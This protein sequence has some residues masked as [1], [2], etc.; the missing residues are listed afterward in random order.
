[1]LLE[2]AENIFQ[3]LMGMAAL[4]LCLVRWIGQRRKEWLYAVGF[5]ICFLLATYYWTGYLVIW[6][7][8][9]DSTDFLDY[10][11]CNMALV[12]LLVL[13]FLLKSPA[14]RRYFHPL[15]L[16]PIP[17]NVWQLTLYLPYG[18][19]AN[20]IFQVTACT[21]IAC[22]ALR[23]LC[24]WYFKNRKAKTPIFAIAS[25]LFVCF[26]FGMWTSTCFDEPVANLYYPFSFLC[27]AD[28]LFLAWSLSRTLA[29]D[30]G[31]ESAQEEGNE[32]PKLW[33][34][35][36]FNLLAPMF[37]IFFLMILMVLY[38]SRV[39]RSV[40]TANVREMGEV[41]IASVTAQM[42]NYLEMT[43]SVMWVTADTVDHMFRNG[44]STQDILKY[45]TEESEKQEKH[46]DDNY[47]GIYG[48]V[49]GEYLDG[50]GW[51]PPED[52][53][54]TQRD[55]Y[56]AAIEAQGE[57]T[58][59]SPYVD[60]QT[61]AVII[62]ISRMLSNGQDV[63]S[64]DVRMNH[65]QEIVEDLQVKGKGYGFVVNSD[66]MLIAHQDENL[67]GQYLNQTESERALMTR[68]TEA[69][70]GTFEIDLNGE[71][72]TAFVHQILGQ[73]YAVIII[74]NTELYEDVSQQL[75]VNVLISM[76]IF[77]LIALFYLLGYRNEQSYSRRI[78]EMRAEEQRRCLKRRQN[79]KQR[80]TAHKSR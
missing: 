24:W 23:S 30:T 46:F 5:F 60:A 47:S 16:L 2:Y 41:R 74:T 26:E 53:D 40:A 6:G 39:I 63:L 10:I 67:K 79:W 62:S 9:P 65:I 77:T 80:Q 48:Y 13:G 59:V 25:L 18:G 57:A 1:M 54:P 51:V 12:I 22:S 3:L 69:Q 31:G 29:S 4:L 17:L 36:R 61:G 49:Q 21:A 37:L 20:S 45:I 50:D 14:E 34:K 28:L 73:W 38:T 71:R 64:L 56:V 70:D 33:K 52:Y 72:C 42:E 75:T 55:W 44:D 11:G 32:K 19:K 8:T 58:I 43:K 68:I 66:A 15:M 76:V 35:S 78:E 27:S 7:Q